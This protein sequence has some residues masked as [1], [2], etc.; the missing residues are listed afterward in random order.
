MTVLA[1]PPRR[2]FLVSCARGT[3]DLIPRAY[4]SEG[5]MIDDKR[6]ATINHVNNRPSFHLTEPSDSELFDYDPIPMDH[7]F[8]AKVKYRYA[9]EWEPIPYP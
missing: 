4:G 2:E 1:L 8:T 3:M 9:G 5:R 6:T 7:A